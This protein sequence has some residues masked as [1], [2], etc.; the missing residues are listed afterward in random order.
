MALRA[1]CQSAPSSSPLSNIE[2]KWAV[3]GT[4]ILTIVHRLRERVVKQL[5]NLSYAIKQISFSGRQTFHS[6]EA[7]NFGLK[8]L[9]TL[10]FFG[11]SS[12]PL[13]VAQAR[14]AV[15]VCLAGRGI[16]PNAFNGLCWFRLLRKLSDCVFIHTLCFNLIENIHLG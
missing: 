3:V 11:L 15:G 4:G 14:A 12:L 16:D 9:F 2:Q 6:M 7:I 13:L 1:D 8:V 10:F 5:N